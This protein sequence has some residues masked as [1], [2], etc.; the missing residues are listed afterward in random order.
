M[1]VNRKLAT[2]SLAFAL[3][4]ALA[5]IVGFVNDSVASAASAEIENGAISYY[6]INVYTKEK[7]K[8][9]KK[10]VRPGATVSGKSYRVNAYSKYYRWTNSTSPASPSLI[11]LNKCVTA[12]NITVQ[13][14]SNA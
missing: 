7:C 13:V 4:F 12:N 2:M 3:A 9:T 10:V 8:G 14:F 5:F 11:G 6:S 1:K